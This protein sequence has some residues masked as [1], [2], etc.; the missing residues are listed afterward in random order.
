MAAAFGL[1]FLWPLLMLL[2]LETVRIDPGNTAFTSLDFVSY[3]W[4]H[5]LLLTL[6]W[7]G[8]AMLAAWA[9]LRSLRTGLILGGLVVSH[10]VLDFVTH[11]PDLPLWPGGPEVGLGLWASVP[12]TLALEGLLF[13]VAIAVYVSE[14]RPR[15][16][17]GTMGL[18][19]LLVVC[20]LLWASGPFAPPPPS[21][22]SVAVA[23]LAL[24]LL[25][26]WAH[27]I[28]RHREVEDAPS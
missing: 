13:G 19:A 1:D 16:R 14:S 11:R 20:T 4:S 5:S 24:W 9:R 18:A 12:A 28:E 6:V 7:G 17:R 3:P 22:T 23:G 21:A 2:G 15:D 26:P 8:L 27:W 25:A 10:W